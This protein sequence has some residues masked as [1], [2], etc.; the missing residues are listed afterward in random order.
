MTAVFDF[1]HR[2][3]GAPVQFDDPENEQWATY[4]GRLVCRISHETGLRVGTFV[5]LAQ[6]GHPTLQTWGPF[7]SI[8]LPIAQVPRTATDLPDLGP[9]PAGIPAGLLTFND[10]SDRSGFAWEPAHRNGHTPPGDGRWHLARIDH[11]FTWNDE[12]RTVLVYRDSSMH[13]FETRQEHRL[14]LRV[15]EIVLSCPIVAEN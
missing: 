4:H 15:E 7:T 12:P 2:H 10:L 8:H 9:F 5:G 3:L 1:D 13:Q 14:T 6:P 11:Q